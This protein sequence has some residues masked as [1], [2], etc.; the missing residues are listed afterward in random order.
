MKSVQLLLRTQ[1]PY[2]VNARYNSLQDYNQKSGLRDH[3]NKW[4]VWVSQEKELTTTHV[5]VF[6]RVICIID[7]RFLI[8]VNSYLSEFS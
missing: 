2:V 3:D 4:K 7:Y 5:P 1:Y 8:C 6:L